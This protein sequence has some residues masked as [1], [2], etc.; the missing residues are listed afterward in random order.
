MQAESVKRIIITESLFEPIHAPEADKPADE[1]GIGGTWGGIA[2]GLFA[3]TSV[4]D[5][6][7][8]GLF[9]G[10]PGLQPKVFLSQYTPQKQT[11]PPMKPI[12]MEENGVT[13]PAARNRFIRHHFRQ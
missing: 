11:S 4:N 1:T 13:N 3:T 9:Y 5:G 7:A 8:N 12:T 10:D 6:G 2:T